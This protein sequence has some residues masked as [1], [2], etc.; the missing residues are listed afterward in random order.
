MRHSKSFA[1]L[2]LSATLIAACGNEPPPPPPSQSAPSSD[3]EA[4]PSAPPPTGSQSGTV[5][6]DIGRSGPI[7]VKGHRELAWEELMPPGE[8]ERLAE[9]YQQHMTMLYSSPIMEGSAADK[10]FQIG[11]FNVVEELDGEKVRIPGFAVPFEFGADARITEFLL[12]PYYGACIHAPPPPPN[13]T[14]YVKLDDPIR[15]RDLSQAVWVYGELETSTA[16][17]ELADA[18]YTLSMTD[19]EDYDY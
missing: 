1:T 16:S 15:L 3:L 4:A 6:T 11:T 19:M 8:E 13:Q 5:R 14:V 9:M 2:L 12:V 18:A 17:T 10:A 7:M